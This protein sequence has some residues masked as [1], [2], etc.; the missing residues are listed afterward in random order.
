MAITIA[1]PVGP[2]QIA[3][4]LCRARFSLAPSN[5]SMQRQSLTIER[6]DILVAELDRRRGDILL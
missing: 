5:L 4:K 3:G 1:Y 6:P 2:A